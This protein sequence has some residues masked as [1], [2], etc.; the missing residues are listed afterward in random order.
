MKPNPAKMEEAMTL[1]MLR[2][3]LSEIVDQGQGDQP[4]VFAAPQETTRTGRARRPVYFPVT[5]A[6]GGSTQVQGSRCSVL[7]GAPFPTKTCSP[8]RR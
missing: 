3:R 5:L 7:D 2:D 1:R 8:G 6:R 4:V